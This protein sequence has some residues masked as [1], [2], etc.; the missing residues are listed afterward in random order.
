MKSIFACTITLALAA[1]AVAAPAAGPYRDE[2]YW[3]GEINKASTV[4]LVEQG[5][6]ARPLGQTIAG[7]IDKVIKEGDEPNAAR[8]GPLQLQTRAGNAPN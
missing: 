7:A 1:S 8:R 6:L 2:F 4:M 3:L 5:V